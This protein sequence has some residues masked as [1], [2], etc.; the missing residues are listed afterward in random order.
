[1]ARVKRIGF[2]LIRPGSAGFLWIPV[3]THSL[4]GTEHMTELIEAVALFIC[5]V[6]SVLGTQL[7]LN[8]ISMANFTRTIFYSH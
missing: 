8:Y 4:S 7:V 2:D 3:F 5:R 6:A 1:M